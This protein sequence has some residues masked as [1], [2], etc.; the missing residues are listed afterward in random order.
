M[1]ETLTFTEFRAQRQAVLRA[2]VLE[3]LAQHEQLTATHLRTTLRAGMREMDAVLQNM[4][5]DG[6]I[7]TQRRWWRLAPCAG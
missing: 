1:T 5:K 7:V 6:Q 3:Q 4:R 2:G